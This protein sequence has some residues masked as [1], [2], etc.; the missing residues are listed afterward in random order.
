MC[1][2]HLVN[3]TVKNVKTVPTRRAHP[4]I[5]RDNVGRYCLEYE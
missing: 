5:L 2:V 1:P 3:D 4:T